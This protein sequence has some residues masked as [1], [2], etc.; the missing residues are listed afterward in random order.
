LQKNT[1]KLLVGDCNEE[2]ACIASDYDSSS[3]LI[4]KKNYQTAKGTVYTSIADM[5]DLD[6]F[7]QVCKQAKT[8]EYYPPIQWSDQKS[9][10]ISDQ[11]FWTESILH[12]LSQTKDIKNLLPSSKHFLHNELYNNKRVTRSQQLWVAGC[13]I[14]AGVAVNHKDTWKEHVAKQI[15]LPYTDLSKPGTS[16]TWSADQICLSDIQE[17]DI[18]LW[19]LTCQNRMPIVFGKKLYH[20]LPTSF[21]TYP[22]LMNEFLISSIAD[23]NDTL[24]YNN[25]NAVKKVYNFC[26]IAKA[27]LVILG[28]M[29]DFYSIYTMYNIPCFKQLL[30]WPDNFVDLGHDNEHPGPKQHKIFADEFLAIYRTLYEQNYIS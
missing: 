10:G 18:V 22:H 25:L 7:L 4:T 3:Y 21:K 27:K 30:C 28:A 6:L 9:N 17:D 29:Y 8:I 26:K 1:Y 14:T 5:E 23:D 24:Y 11:Q 19:Q 13:S 2:I 20:L 15:N 12:F 16:I